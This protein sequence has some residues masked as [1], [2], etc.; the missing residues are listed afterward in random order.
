MPEGQHRTQ[1]LV[2]EDEW[3]IADQI[4]AVL[5]DMQCDV[6]GPVPDVRQALEMLENQLVEAAVLDISL[7]AETSFPIADVLIARSIPFLFMS[8]YVSRDLP[9][10]FHTRNILLKPATTGQ[11]TAQITLLLGQL[12]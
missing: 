10:R 11:L 2:V 3:L 12:S 1:I 5:G 4:E 8:G 9:E 7:G 6:V